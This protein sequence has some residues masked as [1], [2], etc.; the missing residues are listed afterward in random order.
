MSVANLSVDLFEAPHSLLMPFHDIFLS[1]MLLF[2]RLDGKWWHFVV[3]GI[4]NFHFLSI[5]QLSLILG[6]HPTGL[7]YLLWLSGDVP[8]KLAEIISI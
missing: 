2:V 5:C 8:F 1:E 7:F 3:S 6:F 4:E